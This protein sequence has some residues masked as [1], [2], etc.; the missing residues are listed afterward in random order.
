MSVSRLTSFGP[1][2]VLG[3]ALGG[4]YF[5]VL[6]RLLHDWDIDPNYS[7]GYFVPFIAGFMVWTRKEALRLTPVRPCPW[8]MALVALGLLQ[9]F[10]AWVGSE[11]FLQGVSLIVVLAG[12]ILTL[13]G[14]P[15]TALVILPLGYL[16]FMIPLPAIIWN[17][18]AFP[19]ALFASKSA[20]SILDGVGFSVLRE[21]NVITLPNI[22]LQVVEACSGLRSLVTLLALSALVAFVSSLRVWSKWVLFIAAVPVALAC[23]VLRLVATAVLAQN[24]G[25]EMA[26]G[27]MHDFSG[28]VVFGLGLGLLLA[29]AW[30][31]N[32]IPL[33]RS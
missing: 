24:F 21:G 2:L 20:V 16:I 33:A 12:T 25:P 17:T 5:P 11:Y 19:L 26:H 13:W 10:I 23:N 29:T 15:R 1:W 4:L 31:L 22:T 7:H 9:L 18:I 27:F 14:W 8:G 28:F 32:R 30:L 3:L 6:A